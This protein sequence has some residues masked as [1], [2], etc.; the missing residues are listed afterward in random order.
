MLQNCL[1]Q[2]NYLTFLYNSGKVHGTLKCGAYTMVAVPNTNV[3]LVVLDGGD[4]PDSAIK[5]TSVSNAL[6]SSH[7]RRIDLDQVEGSFI[8]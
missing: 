1:F 6:K 5:C 2:G 8:W 3:Y 7:R 4:C